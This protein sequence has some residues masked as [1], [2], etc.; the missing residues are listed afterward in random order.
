M[1]STSSPRASRPTV[2]DDRS[3]GFG[4]LHPLIIAVSVGIVIA[5]IGIIF[6]TIFHEDVDAGVALEWIREIVELVVAGVLGFIGGRATAKREE[7]D[8]QP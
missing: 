8:V 1:P 4:L 5:I 2:D 3:E 6:V 7:P